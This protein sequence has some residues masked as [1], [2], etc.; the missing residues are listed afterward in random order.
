[1][2]AGSS[3]PSSS[4]APRETEF[5]EILGVSID[6][7]PAQIKKGYYQMAKIHHPDKGGSEDK[8]KLISHAYEVLSDPAKR[9]LYNKHGKVVFEKGAA[10]GEFHDPREL[11][12]RMFGG[13]K[14]EEFFGIVSM[15]DMDASGAD[16]A[17]TMI[18]R[19]IDLSDKL[20]VRLKPWLDGKHD[21]FRK[22]TTDLAE[23]LK[24]QDH[25]P[26][27][28]EH[29][30]YVYS[31]EARQ[32]LGGFLGKWAE[33]KEITHTVSQGVGALKSA[34]KLE[35]RQ[36]ELA[37]QQGE[38]QTVDEQA[39]MQAK[40][41]AELIDEGLG[42]MFKFGKLEIDAVIRK[43]CEHLLADLDLSKAERKR[44]AEGVRVMGEIFNKIGATEVKKLRAEEKKKEKE[45][46]K[47]AAHQDGK[48]KGKEKAEPAKAESDGEKEKGKEEA[49]ADDSKDKDKATTSSAGGEG[50]A[51]IDD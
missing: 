3:S 44:R 20:L 33:F 25:G 48:G 49:P 8:F 29:I 40:I 46:K 28:L 30:G 38:P 19:V 47:T 42:A 34:M 31:Q 15:F 13:G 16:E 10:A 9:E 45:D 1:M 11:F 21:Q 36:Q 7:T 6:A 5:Y 26:D 4:G 2:E 32:H 14:F 18:C 22:E 50:L 23:E 35:Q 51:D 39:E 27:L 12:S 41:E 37:E 24:A 43:V 17:T